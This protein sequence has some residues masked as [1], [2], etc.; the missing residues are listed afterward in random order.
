MYLVGFIIRIIHNVQ[1]TERQKPKHVVP[2]NKEP[3]Y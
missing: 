2:L 3:M 1:S